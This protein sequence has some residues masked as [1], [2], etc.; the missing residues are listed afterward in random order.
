VVHNV[1]NDTWRWGVT[2]NS[3]QG[4]D[5]GSPGQIH[6]LNE[7]GYA[8]GG[9]DP[10]Y[11]Y[12]N[13]ATIACT[14]A[15]MVPTGGATLTIRHWYDFAQ[16]NDPGFPPYIPPIIENF[17][18]GMP[19][20]SEDLI[21]HPST[22]SWSD[23]CMTGFGGSWPLNGSLTITGGPVS[24]GT[25]GDHVSAL[26]PCYIDSCHVLQSGGWVTS[27]Y[28]IPSSYQGQLVRV[29]FLFGSE[30]FDV[31][32]PECRYANEPYGSSIIEGDG[33]RIQWI[34]IN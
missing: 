21:S 8:N 32:T 20:I 4:N 11:T 30:D 14:P 13:R 9:S 1:R 2:E 10:T 34:T 3:S 6:F 16:I 31:S 23:F 24:Y 17:D 28:S 5:S 19:I 27:I 26:H 29:G 12:E 25:I 22:V 15:F 33:W 18:G 7:N